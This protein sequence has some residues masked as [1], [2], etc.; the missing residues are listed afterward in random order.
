[1]FAVAEEVVPLTEA[2]PAVDV[3]VGSLYTPVPV[4]DAVVVE[5][6]VPWLQPLRTRPSAIGS[7]MDLFIGGI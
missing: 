5:D 1:M 7:R 3:V 2:E 6:R 4:V